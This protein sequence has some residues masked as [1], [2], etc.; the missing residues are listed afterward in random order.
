MGL[1]QGSGAVGNGTSGARRCVSW[2]HGDP[3]TDLPAPPGLAEEP[4]SAARA[5]SG[6]FGSGQ[7]VSGQRQQVRGQHLVAGAFSSDGGRLVG[8]EVEAELDSRDLEAP[9]E[10][11]MFCMVLSTTM[12]VE[13]EA[14]SDGSGPSCLPLRMRGIEATP[15]TVTGVHPETGANLQ[16]LSLVTIEQVVDW[17]DSGACPVD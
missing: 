13:C 11:G 14:C 8:L 6:R 12:G 10:E 17:T 16:G 4:T 2:P 15:A 7:V 3:R 1:A 5:G 9:G